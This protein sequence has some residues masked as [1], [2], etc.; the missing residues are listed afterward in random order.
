M[1]GQLRN[2]SLLLCLICNVSCV[3]TE[4]LGMSEPYEQL[5]TLATKAHRPPPKPPR[6][7]TERQDTARVPIGWNP[8]VEEWTNN[9]QD[10][11]D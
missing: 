8:S 7:T 4:I 3:K 2:Y 11:I 9:N 5:D 6:D 1:S 10:L